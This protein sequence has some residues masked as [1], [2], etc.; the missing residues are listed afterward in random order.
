VVE[1]VGD[2]VGPPAEVDRH[3]DDAELGAG[4][5][6]GEELGAVAARQPQRVAGRVAPGR[7]AVRD[8]VHPGVELAVGPPAFA[9]DHRDL[10][11]PCRCGAGQAVADVDPLDEV[12]DQLHD[13]LPQV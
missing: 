3:A 13:D 12:L 4:V 5:V 9:V 6:D 2:L 10:V 1:H 7:Q 8:P 11:G